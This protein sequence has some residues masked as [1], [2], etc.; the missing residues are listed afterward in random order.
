MMYEMGRVPMAREIVH[1]S[2]MGVCDGFH[3]K[4]RKNKISGCK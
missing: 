3:K 2:Q 1:W 4:I